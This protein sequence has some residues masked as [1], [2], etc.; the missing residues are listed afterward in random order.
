MLKKSIKEALENYIKA[1]DAD[2]TIT[3]PRFLLKRVKR[4]LAP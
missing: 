1:I 4:L 3:T 2:K